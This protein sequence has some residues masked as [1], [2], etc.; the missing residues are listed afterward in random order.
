MFLQLVFLDYGL[1]GIYGKC[2]IYIFGRWNNKEILP[3]KIE[4]VY[5]YYNIQLS[6]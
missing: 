6:K 1:L 4:T 5:P 3:T 2:N